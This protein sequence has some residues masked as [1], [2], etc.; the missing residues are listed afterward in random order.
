MEQFTNHERFDQ[1]ERHEP[2]RMSQS[3]ALREIDLLAA[4][5]KDAFGRHSN[6]HTAAMAL[7]RIAARE[8]EEMEK[9]DE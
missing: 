1:L 4:E 5:L 9:S 2:P 6:T 3:E 8:K 7:Y